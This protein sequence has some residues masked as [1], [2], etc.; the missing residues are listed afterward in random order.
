M[1]QTLDL[2]TIDDVYAAAKVLDGHAVRTPLISSPV[3][4]EMTGGRIFLKA[5][6]LQR[7]GSFKFRGAF[8]AMH[9]AGEQ[10]EKFGIVAASSGNHAQ[11]V[12]E[13][14]RL[15]GYQAT[16]IMPSD[17]PQT[18]KDR[19]MRSGATIVEYDRA[20]EDREALL[21]EMAKK[22][23]GYAIHPYESFHVI[24]GQGTCGLEMAQDAQ[25]MGLDVDEVLVC[26]GGG[27]LLAGV[28]LAI[29]DHFPNANVRTVEPE[30]YDDQRISHETGERV[31]VNTSE[32]SICD[33]I[34]TP[35][36]GE[37]SFAICYGNLAPG[38]TA[39][40]DAILKAMAFAYEELKLVV[41][42][43]GIVTLAALMA[44]KLDVKGKTVMATISGGN[45][46]PQL[47]ARALAENRAAA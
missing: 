11:G 22:T 35:M 36:P 7:T 19:T 15:K 9:H 44:G 18:K 30:G 14:A 13:A 12:A 5:E 33:A 31:R 34:L 25:A 46:D 41:E 3:L 4:D 2:P 8:N 20:T 40:D 47:T 42:P 17:A 10:G 24:A 16:I 1:L 43:G 27:G 37:R 32:P 38:L 23:G 6:C 26:A 39:T 45:V 29:K 28:T 21:V